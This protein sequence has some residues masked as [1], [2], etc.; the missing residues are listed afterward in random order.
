MPEIPI[1]ASPATTRKRLNIKRAVVKR[2]ITNT[3]KKIEE[4]I[5]TNPNVTKTLI[6]EELLANCDSTEEFSDE[7]GAELDAQSTYTF[8]IKTKLSALTPGPAAADPIPA[9]VSS[10]CKLKLPDLKMR[11]LFRGR[12]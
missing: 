10:N 12:K 7:C 11:H 8:E 3:F 6:N 9:S 1:S 5:T 4:D 2:K